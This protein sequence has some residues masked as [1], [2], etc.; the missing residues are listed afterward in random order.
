MIQRNEREGAV[1]GLQG[2]EG[3]DELKQNLFHF[4][5]HARPA[6]DRGK[7]WIRFQAAAEFAPHY[8]QPVGHA[9]TGFP[10]SILQ[11]LVENRRKIPVPSRTT[12]ISAELGDR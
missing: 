5:R 4:F 8:H 7:P 3:S 1:L 2:G 10:Q 6:D 11:R 12:R 9:N